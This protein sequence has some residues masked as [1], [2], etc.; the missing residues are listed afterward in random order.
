ML[1][2]DARNA[3]AGKVAMYHQQA[4]GVETYLA[5]RGFGRN[6]I[7]R[8]QLGF[9][10]DTGDAYANRLTIPYLSPAGPWLV[11]YRCLKTHDHKSKDVKCPKYLND[12][13]VNLHLF[14][15]AVLG[16]VDRVVLVEGELDAIAVAMCGVP[17]VGFPGS[18]SWQKNRHWRW[19]F[20]NV[21]QV[22][23]VADG[24]EP[25]VEKK[26]TIGVGEESAKQVAADLRQALPDL[27]VQLYVM[28]IPHDSNSYIAE[29]GAFDYLEKIG[30]L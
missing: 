13:D 7:D 18:Q 20:D 15:A 10:G 27:D 12:D 26:K 1:S 3:L 29:H 5:D 8:F 14:N 21:D 9:T 17:A 6:A 4:A 24:D 16:E 25:D 30:W 2:P 28:P 22:L 23:I 11:K 19:C